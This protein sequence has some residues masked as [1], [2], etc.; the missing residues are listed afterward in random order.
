LTPATVPENSRL[1]SMIEK[2]ALGCAGI[3]ELGR[4]EK[5]TERQL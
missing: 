4:K 5:C 3:V 1:S 2:N